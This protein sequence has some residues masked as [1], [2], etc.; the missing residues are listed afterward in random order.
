MLTQCFSSNLGQIWPILSTSSRLRPKRGWRKWPKATSL[1]WTHLQLPWTHGN[2]VNTKQRPKVKHDFFHT[3]LKTFLAF[4]IFASEFPRLKSPR[5][6]SSVRWPRSSTFLKIKVF[7]S[8]LILAMVVMICRPT[9][10]SGLYQSLSVLRVF[11]SQSRFVTLIPVT[12]QCQHLVIQ[13]ILTH[14]WPFFCV[15]VMAGSRALVP[16][17]SFG[18]SMKK[19]RPTSKTPS[20]IDFPWWLLSPWLSLERV[21]FASDSSSWTLGAA[22]EAWTDARQLWFSLWN[23]GKWWLSN[24][25]HKGEGKK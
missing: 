2:K 3:A 16:S 18:A 15:S 11:S 6:A 7:S 17:T 23:L 13:C 5:K 24:E 9:S 21:R 19:H 14:C 20:L 4:W 1:N 10:S 12:G 8:T 25:V 22:L